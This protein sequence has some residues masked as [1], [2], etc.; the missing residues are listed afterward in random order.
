MPP[1]YRRWPGHHLLGFPL[2]RELR[3]SSPGMPPEPRLHPGPGALTNS[4]GLAPNLPTPW[5]S[6]PTPHSYLELPGGC[7]PGPAM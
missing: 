6:P 3:A 7:Q 4:H 2:G 1:S 5:E